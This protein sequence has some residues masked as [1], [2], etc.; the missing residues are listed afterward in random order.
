MWSAVSFIFLLGGIAVVLVAFGKFDYLG[1]H[2]ST[3]ATMARPAGP[4][5]A[6]ITPAQ[7]ATVKFMVVASLLFLA[8]VLI[9]G[10]LAHYR[11]EPGDFY[12]FDLSG[13][14]PV[15]YSGPGICKR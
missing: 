8:Q 12:G 2:G 14:S 1:W 13:C 6:Q 9:G 7:G 15:I 5:I 11:A 4:R 3:P 10:A